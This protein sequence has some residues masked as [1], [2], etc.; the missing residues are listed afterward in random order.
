[1]GLTSTWRKFGAFVHS[2]PITRKYGSQL[3]DYKMWHKGLL[4][5][6]QSYGVSWHEWLVALN[7]KKTKLLSMS[8][9]RNRSFPS[10]CIGYS[11]LPESSEL[12]LLG[13]HISLNLSWSKYISSI[14]DRASKRVGCL[15]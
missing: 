15:Y 9:S 6:L 10:V 1:M 5:E 4:Q 2:V 3:P 8:H 12:R 7:A 14:A 11:T 13:L